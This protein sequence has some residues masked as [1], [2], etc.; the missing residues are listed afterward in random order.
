MAT[1]VLVHGAYQGGWIWKPV[2]DRLRA[3]GHR[4]YAPTLDGVA[5]LV[6]VENVLHAARPGEPEDPPFPGR[7]EDGLVCLALDAPEAVH[8]AHIVDAVHVI[9]ARGALCNAVV[10]LSRKRRQE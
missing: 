6:D 9:W 7:V 5:A 2:V 1:F 4:V 10:P 3:S 8:A